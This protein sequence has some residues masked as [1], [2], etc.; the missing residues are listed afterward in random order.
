MRYVLMLV[1]LTVGCANHDHVINYC[2]V[3]NDDGHGTHH[4]MCAMP[5]KD[6]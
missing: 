1:L 3:P 5:D 2:D 4:E 6:H